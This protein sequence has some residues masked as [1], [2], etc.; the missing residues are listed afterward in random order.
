VIVNQTLVFAHP[1]FT[2]GTE[3][4][5]VAGTAMRRGSDGKMG[6]IGGGDDAHHR[7]VDS[8]LTLGGC[9]LFVGEMD[10]YVGFEE[11]KSDANLCGRE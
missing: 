7:F 9:E 2:R 4:E 1:F 11:L 6:R 10:L 5:K 3:P 8:A